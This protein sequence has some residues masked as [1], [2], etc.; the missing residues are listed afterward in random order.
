MK[1]EM[2][3]RGI[4]VE[5]WQE[6]NARVAILTA[7]IKEQQATEKNIQQTLK[8]AQDTFRDT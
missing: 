6:L 2:Q 3:Q 1:R 5:M 4:T 7:I 8:K